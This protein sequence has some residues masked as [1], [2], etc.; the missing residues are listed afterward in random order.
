MGSRTT[1]QDV[2]EWAGVSN[3]TVSNVINGKDT[4]RE[5]TRQKVLEA[6]EEL[7]YRPN[8]SAQ[9]RLQSGGQNSLGM[10][11]K[12]V[13]NPYFA[14]IV[15]GAQ[16]RAAEE[17]YTIMVSSSERRHEWEGRVVDLFVEKDV[18]GIVIN[19][20]LDRDAD[21][22]HLFTLKR[23]N[24]PFVLL[25]EV[26]GLKAN[27]VDVDNVEAS[28]EVTSYLIGQGHEEVIHFGGP[29]DSMHS[30]ERIEGFQQAFFDSKLVYSDDYV[31]R[32]GARREEGYRAGKE[33]FGNRPA[34]ERPTAVICYNDMLAIGLLRALREIG[35][36]IPGE[37]SVTGFDD[38]QSSKYAPLPLTSVRVPT[39]QMG[40][41]AVELLLRQIEASGPAKPVEERLEAELKVRSSTAPVRENLSA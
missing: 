27:L 6:I 7:N 36:D 11:V 39:R 13:N 16:E 31:L 20:L 18:E 4:V 25:E 17:G 37:V 26:R 15:T 23:R 24:V 14:E 33:Y 21:L 29:K 30:D 35:I 10:V 32:V 28:R 34:S 2:A 40:K 12:E 41:V 9:R 1:I 3:G 5:V 8:A 38:V 22:S 19:P